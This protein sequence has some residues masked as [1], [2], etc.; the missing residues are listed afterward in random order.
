MSLQKCLFVVIAVAFTWPCLAGH[1]SDS[2]I[3]LKTRNAEDCIQAA[4]KKVLHGIALNDLA[5][6]AGSPEDRKNLSIQTA[7]VQAEL[8]VAATNLD[9]AIQDLRIAVRSGSEDARYY[10]HLQAV[11]R[12]AH[13][14][15]S[16]AALWRDALKFRNSIAKDL[17]SSRMKADDLCSAAKENALEAVRCGVIIPVEHRLNVESQ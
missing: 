14:C 2:V 11:E 12:Y 9:K 3:A 7:T 13:L 1:E 15:T 4:A 8:R 5:G 16:S 10:A 17:L 6:S